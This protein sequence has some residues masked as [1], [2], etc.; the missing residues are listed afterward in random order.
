MLNVMKPG[1]VIVDLA[2]TNG[3]NVVQ[4]KANKIDLEDVAVQEMLISYDG[5]ARW[6]LALLA[7]FGGH[8]ALDGLVG[9]QV[10]WG[11]A[12]ALHSPIM[13]V[14]NVISGMTAVGGMLLLANGTFDAA[15]LVPDSPAHWMG[16]VATPL[17]FVNIVG[18]FLVTGKM[19]DLFRQ[20][21]DPE[22]YFGYYALPAG[23]LVAGLGGRYVTGFGN[24]EGVA[25][26]GI[27]AAICSI[28]ASGSL[29][30]VDSRLFSRA[31]FEH[32]P[33]T[34]SASPG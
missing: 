17:S 27:A 4:T 19:F 32:G 2:A 20:S 15:G 25:D 8:L 16:A 23:A 29:L 3:G 22:D 21:E 34:S 26:V 14:T 1:S 13:A 18:G 12:P 9:Y 24:F 7:D 5:E 11:V 31:P 6:P 30:G 10:V 28:A 33:G